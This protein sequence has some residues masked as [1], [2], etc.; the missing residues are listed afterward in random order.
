MEERRTVTDSE[1]KIMELLW[2]GGT[3][4]MPEL[5]RAL[6]EETGWSKHTVISLLKR[7]CQKGSAE[8]VPGTSPMQYRARL[9]REEAVRQETQS[10]LRKVFGGKSALLIRSLVEQ[11]S[12]TQEEI[13][14]LVRELETHRKKEG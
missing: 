12:L 3:W 10:V 14:D 4:T 1:W 8:I 5:T 2:R 13:D 7:M 11:E 9:P 6:V